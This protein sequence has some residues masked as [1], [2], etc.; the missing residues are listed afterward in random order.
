MGNKWEG[1][2]DH[3]WLSSWSSERKVQEEAAALALKL[4]REKKQREMDAYDAWYKAQG[5]RCGRTAES[6]VTTAGPQCP[7]RLEDEAGLSSPIEK[8]Q[9]A[10]KPPGALDGV[11]TG[12]I[13]PTKEELIAELRR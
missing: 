6:P 10:E 12:R 2:P 9:A 11:V 1:K 3:A 8:T 7:E 5:R 4:E 13:G